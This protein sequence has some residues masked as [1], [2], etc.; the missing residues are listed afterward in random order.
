MYG[1]LLFCPIDIP[2]PNLIL[3]SLVL[4]LMEAIFQV[5]EF[6]TGGSK[7]QMGRVP[8]SHAVCLGVRA[9]LVVAKVVFIACRSCTC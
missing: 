9:A 7:V 1:L 6:F 3:A 4:V 5:I 8:K 2:C